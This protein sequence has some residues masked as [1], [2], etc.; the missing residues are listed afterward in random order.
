MLISADGTGYTAIPRD[1]GTYGV[2]VVHPGELPEIIRGFASKAEAERWIMNR[3][4]EQGTGD[5]PDITT[6]AHNPDM[7]PH[8]KP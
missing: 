5:L 8:H 3:V 4:G 2:E 1:D 7:T 6:A